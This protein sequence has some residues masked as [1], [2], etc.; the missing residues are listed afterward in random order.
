MATTTTQKQ[1]NTPTTYREYIQEMIF[2]IEGLYSRAQ[3]LRDEATEEEK[4]YWN[5]FIGAYW[6]FRKPL[7]ELDDSITDQRGATIV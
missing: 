6:D 3:W 5:Q 7:V 1:V 2:K 4:K